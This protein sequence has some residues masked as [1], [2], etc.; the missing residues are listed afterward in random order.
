MRAAYLLLTIFLSACD[1]TVIKDVQTV[2]HVVLVWFN[3]SVDESYIH[4]VAVASQ[5]LEQISGVITISAGLPIESERP[6]VD[7]SFDLGLII[8]FDSVDKMRSYVSDPIHK[9]FVEDYLQGKLD[10]LL[11]YDF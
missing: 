5:Q 7:D 4:Q 9:K 2:N 8:R 11:V 1:S 3:R 6:V 10:K